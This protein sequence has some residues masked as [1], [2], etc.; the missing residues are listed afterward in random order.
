MAGRLRAILDTSVLIGADTDL[1]PDG[2]A[3]S[4]ATLA[5]LHFGV[6][7]SGSDGRRKSRLQRLA[8]IE[9]SFEAVPIDEQ[10]ARSYGSLAHRV[11]VSGRNP[12]GLTMDVL[13]AATAQAHA[14]P[15]LTRDERDF[16]AFADE[17]EVRVI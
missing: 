3:I 17:V 13:I 14:V 7:M 4:A 11:M 12:R 1:L 10:V 16:A 2:S 8:Q 6:H 15:L 5:E 9:S